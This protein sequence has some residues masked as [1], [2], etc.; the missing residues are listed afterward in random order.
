M[1][2][3]RLKLLTFDVMWWFVVRAVR[4]GQSVKKEIAEWILFKCLPTFTGSNA[5][6][7][8]NTHQ[9][10]LLQRSHVSL[11]SDFPLDT[12][13]FIE[14]VELRKDALVLHQTAADSAKWK[15][16][17][18]TIFHLSGNQCDGDFFIGINKRP[19][20]AR[21]PGTKFSHLGLFANDKQYCGV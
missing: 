11:S 12:L 21:L 3:I 19:F 15:L 1:H 16:T 18:H 17:T 14:L 7:G 13:S 4:K 9:T 2:T 10:L 8:S 5:N 6:L 20:C